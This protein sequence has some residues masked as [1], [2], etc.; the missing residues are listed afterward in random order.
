LDGKPVKYRL[1][2]ENSYTLY[3]AGEDGKDDGG[4]MTPASDTAFRDMWRRRDCVWP[5]PAT[6]EEIEEHRKQA[7][8]D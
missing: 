3:S 4:D 6:P 1:A 7:G 5:V 8:R 2:N